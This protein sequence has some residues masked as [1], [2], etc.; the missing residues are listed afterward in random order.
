MATVDPLNIRAKISHAALTATLLLPLSMQPITALVFHYAN[1]ITCLHHLNNKRRELKIVINIYKVAVEFICLILALPSFIDTIVNISNENINDWNLNAYILLQWS[2]GLTSGIY[3]YEC[4]A[5]SIRTNSTTR[6]FAQDFSHWIHH[7]CHVVVSTWLF[8]RGNPNYYEL[9]VVS[10][11]G[12]WTYAST[13]PLTI[14]ITRYF[15]TTTLKEKYSICVFGSYFFA[16]GNV[17][18][19]GSSVGL[20]LYN[21]N[22][23][24]LT[25]QIAFWPMIVL[26]SVDQMFTS[27]ALKTMAVRQRQKMINSNN[28]VD[29]LNTRK[30]GDN[31][32]LDVDI[33]DW[34]TDVDVH[35][36]GNSVFNF[37]R[38]ITHKFS[39]QFAEQI[40]DEY[41]SER[42]SLAKKSEVMKSNSVDAINERIAFL[43]KLNVE[44]TITY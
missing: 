20:Y 40:F 16:V 29:A 22:K 41:D 3:I 34:N 18:R 35:T 27:F 44:N 6:E 17:F 4:L 25:A 26:W 36:H 9:R 11:Y 5:L 10:L 32:N 15:V 21:W 23:M 13:I 39:Q 1:K 12:F 2:I 38:Q 31:C 24:S 14:A 33:V 28:N 7:F 43:P 42:R 37:A 19:C 30:M 8:I